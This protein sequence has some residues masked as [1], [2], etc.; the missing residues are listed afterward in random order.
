[1]IKQ[2]IYIMNMNHFTT[3][4]PSNA[5]PDLY[6][7]NRAGHYFTTF[8]NPIP[9]HGQ[10]QVAVKDISYVHTVRTIKDESLIIGQVDDVRVFFPYFESAH[11][12]QPYNLN[13]HEMEWTI[14][15]HKKEVLL[16]SVRRRKETPVE[17]RNIERVLSLISTMNRLGSRMWRWDYSRDENAIGFTYLVD[18]DHAAY[19]F[20][21]SKDLAEVLQL[22]HQL[23][24]PFPNYRVYPSSDVQLFNLKGKTYTRV[25]PSLNHNVNWKKRKFEVTLLPLHRMKSTVIKFPDF[26]LV[27][28][29]IDQ[30]NKVMERYGLVVRIGAK[31]YTLTWTYTHNI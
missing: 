6:P 28:N 19:G 26:K 5:Q 29:F 31:P 7:N 25:S 14:E 17:F 2:M 24:L 10:W 15:S 8:Q 22:N 9:L 23:F 4:F 3:M 20:Y 16:M 13:Q 21:F 30:L 18:I 11:E 27:K 1:M 12:V